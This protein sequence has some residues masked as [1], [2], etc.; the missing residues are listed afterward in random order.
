MRVKFV[1]IRFVIL[2]RYCRRK[3]KP[4]SMELIHTDC[5]VT[6]PTSFRT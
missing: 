4:I 6:H 1:Q 2:G 3:Y 5:V